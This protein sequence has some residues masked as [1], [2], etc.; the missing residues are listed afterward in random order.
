MFNLNSFIYGLLLASVISLISYRIKFLSIDGL[1]GAFI[2]GTIIFGIGGIPWSIPLISFFIS[3]SVLTKMN[4]TKNPEA[5]R[6]FLDNG[7]RNIY[8]VL[9][10]GSIPALIILFNT[11]F[12]NK[13]SIYLYISSIAAV[14]ADTWGT[15]IGTW[16]K[17]AT[18]NILSLKKINQGESGGI[19]IK[20]TLGSICGAIFV[21]TFSMI[22]IELKFEYFVIIVISG[23]AG[24]LADSLFGAAIQAQYLCS[25]CGIVVDHK[26]HCNK[27]TDFKRGFQIISNNIVNLLAGVTGVLVSLLLILIII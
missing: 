23:V 3:S 24:S 2:I 27:K 5:R 4:P 18:Y 6:Y 17:T 26:F 25:N 12:E 22:Y 15:E 20:G 8:Q 16:T 11:F 13:L 21:T 7:Q 9:A 10:N 1:L 19:S 14:C